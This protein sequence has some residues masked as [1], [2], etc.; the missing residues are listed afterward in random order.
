ME[1]IF[2]DFNRIPILS[3]TEC[4]SVFIELLNIRKLWLQRNNWHPAFEITGEQDN[5]IESTCT[6]TPWVLLCT[7]IQEIKVGI[8]MT[9]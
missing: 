3:P 6:T 5:D 2:L 4:E 1:N 8:S 7:W 9:N